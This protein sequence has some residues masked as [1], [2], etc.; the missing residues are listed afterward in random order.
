MCIRDR[1]FPEE[2]IEV[3]GHRAFLTAKMLKHHRV[4]AMTDLDA[5]IMR[6]IHFMPIQSVEQGIAAAQKEHG[7]DM[8]TLVVPNGKAVLPLLNRKMSTLIV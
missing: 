4:Y 1:Q 6:R 2:K 8:K 3:G 5:D 7:V